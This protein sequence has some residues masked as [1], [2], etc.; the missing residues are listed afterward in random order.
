MVLHC[1][2]L[3]HV[4]PLGLGKDSICKDAYL[5]HRH[6]WLSIHGAAQHPADCDPCT[7]MYAGRAE[8]PRLGTIVA[9]GWT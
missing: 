5:R 3:A 9:R 2:E 7:R 8:L 4:A 6:H 1:G